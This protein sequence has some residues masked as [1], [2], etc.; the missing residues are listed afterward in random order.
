[1]K[2]LQRRKVKFFTG[3]QMRYLDRHG[4]ERVP[5]GIDGVWNIQQGSTCKNLGCGKFANCKCERVVYD[6]IRDD[7]G[8]TVS[9]CCLHPYLG[10]TTKP[11][12]YE[13]AIIDQDGKAIEPC[14]T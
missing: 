14:Q 10:L 8:R 6:L 5:K 4:V 7:D 11:S 13:L 1:M 9:K 2:I 3:L 12:G